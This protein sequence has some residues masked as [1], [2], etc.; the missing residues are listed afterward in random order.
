[1][2]LQNGQ[3]P[4]SLVRTPASR[5]QRLRQVV[6]IGEETTG[7]VA[8]RDHARACEGGQIDRGRGLQIRGIGH[9]VG[10]NEAAL[11][12]RAPDLDGLPEHGFDDIAGLEG[13]APGQVL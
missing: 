2:A 9:G 5:L 3:S 6:I 10:Q 11:G 12:V 13:P 7:L 8:E 4:R 1:M